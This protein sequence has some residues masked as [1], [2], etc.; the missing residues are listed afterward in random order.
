MMN[1]IKIITFLYIF[2]TAIHEEKPSSKTLTSVRNSGQLSLD[3]EDHLWMWW[4]GTCPNGSSVLLQHMAQH[5]PAAP[6]QCLSLHQRHLHPC[7]A[8]T[9]W[10]PCTQANVTLS[11]S[12]GDSHSNA[13]LLLTP[14]STSCPVCA[15]SSPPATSVFKGD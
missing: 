4:I 10:E 2:R 12:V 13:H 11:G 9:C 7:G 5:S 8:V 15:F 14:A 1:N 3:N 6:Q